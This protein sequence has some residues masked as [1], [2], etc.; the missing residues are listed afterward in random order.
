MKLTRQSFRLSRCCTTVLLLFIAGCA[1]T[2][3]G[4]RY[5][6]LSPI[7]QLAAD[8]AQVDRSAVALGV[9]PVTI[10]DELK[11][12]RIVTRPSTGRY[13]YSEFNRWAGLLENDLSRVLGENL[14]LLLGTD[15]IGTYPW[16]NY[17]K[18][19]YR[20]AVEVLRFDGDLSGDVVLDARWSI[21]D[22]EGTGILANGRSRFRQPVA[23]PAYE[24][25]VRAESLAL[26][27][28]SRTLAEAIRHLHQ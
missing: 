11:S 7:D 12:P 16:Q 14:G 25:L 15:R 18:P 21:V 1:G 3:P 13:Q 6:G 8:V 26:A 2:A 23:A 20:I 28:L 4:H 10:P 27:D 17:F 5:Y 24:S 22:A 9:G 19:D